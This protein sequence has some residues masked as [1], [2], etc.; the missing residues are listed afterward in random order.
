MCVLAIAW[1]AHPRWKLV[2]AANRDEFHDRPAELL[3]RWDDGETIAGR[4]VRAGGTWLA[5]SEKGRF[6]AVTNLR[7][8][9]NPDPSLA[10]RGALVIDLARGSLPPNDRLGGFNPFNAVTIGRDGA[11]FLSN[12]PRSVR[13][14]L[15][16]GFH[17]M[18]NRPLDPPWRKTVRLSKAIESWLGSDD[19]DPET[20]F[21]GLRDTSPSTGTADDPAPIFVENP[22]YGTRCGTIV[23]VDTDDAGLII[24]RHFDRTGRAVG[25]TAI[26]FRWG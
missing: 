26:P 7:G 12:Q 24:E 20:L 13:H 2:V 10:S 23:L 15:A 18:S 8:H 17:A 1:Q 11:Y 6:A 5:V 22:I 21:A 19:H 16:P 14:S 3:H 9:G 25:D 4:D